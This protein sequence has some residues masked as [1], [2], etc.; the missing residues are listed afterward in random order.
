MSSDNVK[1]HLQICV[2]FIQTCSKKMEQGGEFAA[3]VTRGSFGTPD[4]DEHSD[5]D[6]LLLTQSSSQEH[7]TEQRKRFASEL[8]PLLSSF[9]GEHV[10]EPSILICLY[11]TGPRLL[12][13][14][15]DFRAS[16]EV[17]WCFSQEQIHWL[18][19]GESVRALVDP[20]E[21]AQPNVQWMEDRFWTW[22]HY[23][24]GKCRRGEIFDGVGMVGFLREHVLGPLQLSLGGYPPHSVRRLESRFPESVGEFAKT[25]PEYS[26]QSCLK[27]L[28]NCVS[29]YLGL[30]EQIPE[31]KLTERCDARKAVL[32]DLYRALEGD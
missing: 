16:H 19:Q 4:F 28:E 21:R 13:V 11:N 18:R 20:P 29:L 27:A 10:G 24:V 17:D 22:I 31:C 7:G 25:V 15:L 5:L 14:D 32:S 26:R 9:T 30:C 3:L 8:G 2:D 23:G 1:N 6:L 12:H